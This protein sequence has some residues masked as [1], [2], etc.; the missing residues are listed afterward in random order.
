MYCF[1][2][3]RPA[4]GDNITNQYLQ[5]PQVLAAIQSKLGSMVGAPSGYIARQVITTLSS[6]Y[7][8]RLYTFV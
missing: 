1:V 6:W 4:A 8:Q 5:N 3:G 2:D 7:S